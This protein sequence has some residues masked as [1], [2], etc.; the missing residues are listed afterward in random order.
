MTKKY[1]KYLI[2]TNPDGGH[3]GQTAGS[4]SLKDAK[5]LLKQSEYCVYIFSIPTNIHHNLMFKYPLSNYYN[6]L[7]I[8][9]YN[10]DVWISLNNINYQENDFSEYIEIVCEF[11]ELYKNYEYIIK[12]FSI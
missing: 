7:E 5:K 10:N 12:F 8:N 6:C 2:I 11:N 3:T 1:P 4:I 9:K